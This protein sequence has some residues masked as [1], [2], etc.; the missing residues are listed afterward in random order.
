MAGPARR[1]RTY[2][3]HAAIL[4]TLVMVACLVVTAVPRITAAAV[5]RGLRGWLDDAPRTATDLHVT[6]DVRG[7]L[8]DV[9]D[10]AAATRSVRARL[11]EPLPSLISRQ[12]FTATV[13]GLQASAEFQPFNGAVKP[14]IEVVAPGRLATLATLTA[15]RW[16]ATGRPRASSA[17]ALEVVVAEPTAKGLQLTVGS[18][19]TLGTVD[20]TAKVHVVGLF[21]VSDPTGAPWDDHPEAVRPLNDLTAANGGLSASVVTDLAGAEVAGATRGVVRYD[22]RFRMADDRLD[23][24][25]IDPVLSAITRAEQRHDPS[26]RGRLR[27]STDTLLARFADRLPTLRALEAIVWSGLVVTLLGLIGLSARLAIERRRAELALLRA[28]GAS[29]WTLSATVVGESL[30]VCVPAAVLGTVA[31]LL[32]AGVAGDDGGPGLGRFGG[33]WP[34]G[35]ADWATVAIAVFAVLV[36][37]LLAAWASGGGPGANRRAAS[38]RPSGRR[39]AALR[40]RAGRRVTAEV[41]VLV[42][43]GVGVV[44]LRRRGLATTDGT[45]P[46]LTCVPVLLAAGAALITA[47]LLPLVLRVVAQAAGRRRGLAAFLG[48]AGASRGTPAGVA[49]LVFLVLA[50]ATG[51]FTAA[52]ATAVSAAHDRA[53]DLV[54]GADTV[55]AGG[56]FT[57][58]TTRQL[59]EVPGVVAVSP[60]TTERNVA[61]WGPSGEVGQAQIV[62]IDPDSYARVMR[63]SGITT[64]LPRVLREAAVPG[65]GPMPAVVSREVAPDV[66]EGATVEIQNNEY[67]F[68]PAAVVD[69]FP[70]FGRDDR[71]VVLAAPSLPNRLNRALTPTRFH[72][73]GSSASRARLRAVGDAGQLRHLAAVIGHDVAAPVTPTEVTTRDEYRRDLAGNGPN[74]AVWSV[75]LAGALGSVALGLL[76]VSLGVAASARARGRTLSRLRTLGMPGRQG[77]RILLYELGPLLGAGTLAGCLAGVALPVLLAAPLRLT[78]F[79]DGWPVTPRV[80]PRMVAFSAVF[81]AVAL[82]VAVAVESATNR[83]LRLGRALRLGEDG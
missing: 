62:I 56:S 63:R 45:D 24:S 32:V 59:A 65:R 53:C 67:E 21:T 76:A 39:S 79:A 8:P 72:I 46:Y 52:V 42:G 83:W 61:L 7:G 49:S 55:V 29:L 18:R 10:A 6:A 81:V 12:W 23:A 28:R 50:I 20:R 37:A 73:A 74:A 69:E 27:T 31:G 3:G 36:P 60:V 17:G 64:P 16:P 48:L 71:Y 30:L 44:L 41:A 9:E 26:A 40:W 75:Y 2:T 43:A 68:R 35:R 14:T 15:G 5:D 78:A 80:D 82:V 38:R 58:Q 19:F 25:K 33:G 66:T 11:S 77:R 34:G 54:V 1:I 57:P 13:A 51:F 47:R 4:A 70:G 22:W